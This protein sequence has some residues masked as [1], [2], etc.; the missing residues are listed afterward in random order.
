[1]VGEAA[2]NKQARTHHGLSL[3]LGCCTGDVTAIICREQIRKV[4]P[5]VAGSDPDIDTLLKGLAR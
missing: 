4:G 1:M 3:R 5:D 2:T